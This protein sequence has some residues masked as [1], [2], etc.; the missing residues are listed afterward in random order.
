M[1]GKSKLG[2]FIIAA[3]IIVLCIL[4]A[5]SRNQTFQNGTFVTAGG[6]IG[7]IHQADKEIF[8]R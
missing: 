8:N 2:F 3:A 5:Q 6:M 7:H 4:L 1:I